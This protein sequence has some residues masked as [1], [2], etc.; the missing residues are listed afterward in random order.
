M[1][2]HTIFYGD[3]TVPNPYESDAPEIDP[4]K[5]KAEANRRYLRVMKLRDEE[6]ERSM[7]SFVK[8]INT[9]NGWRIVKVIN[10]SSAY[11]HRDEVI[12]LPL[13]KVLIIWGR[14]NRKLRAGQFCAKPHHYLILEE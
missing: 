6:R 8:F 5:E 11:Y 1:N 2:D 9:V 4:A 13:T 10:F 12:S 14:F 7:T 3:R